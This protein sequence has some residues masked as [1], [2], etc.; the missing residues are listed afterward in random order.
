VR[1]GWDRFILRRAMTGILPDLVRQNDTVR[2]KQSADLAQRL[3]SCW[4]GLAAEI[5][6]IGARDAEREYLDLA[7]IKG[8]LAK[9]STLKDDAADD[10]NLRML[11]RSLI[12]SRFLKHE[13]SAI[14]NGSVL[15]H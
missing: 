1:K 15:S 5:R 4:P 2:G 9:I 11:I 12:F 3:Q 13:E 6:N 7:K 14:G 8:A 10:S